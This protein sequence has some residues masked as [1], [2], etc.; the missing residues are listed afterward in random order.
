M[1]PRYLDGV[2]PVD[3]LANNMSKPEQTSPESTPAS[4]SKPKPVLPPGARSIGKFK[5]K[6]D[7]EIYEMFVHPPDPLFN[8]THMGQSAKYHWAGVLSQFIEAF[9]NEDGSSLNGS[10]KWV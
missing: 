1:T 6:S 5:R 10:E 9:D 8:R 2:T 3:I 7:G 4:P